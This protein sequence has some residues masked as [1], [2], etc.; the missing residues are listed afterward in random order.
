MWLEW[1]GK[2]HILIGIEKKSEQKG[3]IRDL[4]VFIRE[5]RLSRRPKLILEEF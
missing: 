5:M 4:G 2:G 3:G 1:T